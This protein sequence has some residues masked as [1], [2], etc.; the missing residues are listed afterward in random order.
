V[1]TFGDSKKS[2]A[3]VGEVQPFEDGCDS[4]DGH[5]SVV[6]KRTARESAESPAETPRFSSS[7]HVSES[8]AREFWLAF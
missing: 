4:G 6:V 3:H 7:P 1:T 2:A 5:F 8:R